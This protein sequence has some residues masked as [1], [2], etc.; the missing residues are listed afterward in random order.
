MKLEKSN[1][2]KILSKGRKITLFGASHIAQKTIRKLDKS[3]IIAVVDN[4]ENLHGSIFMNHEV[5][6]PNSIPKDSYIIICSTAITPISEQLVSLGY[7]IEKDFTISPSLNDLLIIEELEKI[8]SSFYFTSGSVSVDNKNYGG[9]LYKV[10]F[11]NENI[12]IKKIYSGPCYGLIKYEDKIHFIDTDKGIM[13]YDPNTDKTSTLVKTPIDSRA[14]GISFNDSTK[15]FYVSCSNMDAIIEYNKDFKE[16]KR[17]H[18]SNKIGF[19]GTSMHHCNDNYSMGNSL[20]VSMFSS[21]G[22]WKRGVFDGCVAEF[23]IQTGKRINNIVDNLYMPHNITSL[24]GSLHVL[25]SLPGH[26]RV[27]NFDISGTFSGFTRG[28]SYNKGFYF[29]GQS[30]NRNFSK[31]LGMSN[32]ISV[33]CGITIFEPISKVSRTI[34]LSNK[35]GEIHS[36]LINDI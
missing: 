4:S 15:N 28:L 14:H 5:K 3:S 11:D 34:K 17:F 12:E 22:N 1:L 19:Y 18:L 33:D 31:V 13:N 35:I 36:I 7:N 8:S 20:F 25:D 21:S 9:G 23:D 2:N 32:N 24:N 27:E 29:I 30:K 10:F 6:S 26:L 16:V